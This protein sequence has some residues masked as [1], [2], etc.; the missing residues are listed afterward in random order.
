MLDEIERYNT[1]S[2]EMFEDTRCL[3]DGRSCPLISSSHSSDVRHGYFSDEDRYLDESHSLSSL[4]D[5]QRPSCSPDGTVD[6]PLDVYPAS[7]TPKV[8]IS[9]YGFD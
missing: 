6:T 8:K 5:G 3:F 9:S 2:N 1:N 7:I 4:S